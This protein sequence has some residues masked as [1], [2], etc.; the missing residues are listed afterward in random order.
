MD[1]EAEEFA[2]LGVAA[3]DGAD[4]VVGAD[5]FE[6]DAACGDEAAVEFGAVADFGHV[7]FGA[8]EDGEEL[9]L[10][11]GDA[12]F[13][14]ELGGELEDAAGVGDDLDGFDAGDFVEEPAAGGVHELGVAFELEQFEDGDALVGRERARGVR[15]KK[16]STLAGWSGRG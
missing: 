9:L 3:E 16:R 13:A 4:G 5:L 6:V 10:R 15:A 1:V 14:E 11:A 8:A 12:G 7:G 2:V